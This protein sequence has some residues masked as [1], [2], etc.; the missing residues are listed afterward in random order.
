MTRHSV[1]ENGGFC[2]SM[3]GAMWRKMADFVAANALYIDR[4]R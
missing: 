3:C 4:S 2:R 1:A